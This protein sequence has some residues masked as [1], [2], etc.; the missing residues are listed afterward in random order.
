MT[1]NMMPVYAT[2][3]VAALAVATAVYTEGMD[4]PTRTRDATGWL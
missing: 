2:I 4:V 3:I 1:T